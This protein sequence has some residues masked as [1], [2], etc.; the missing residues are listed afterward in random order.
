MSK[1]DVENH[2]NKFSKAYDPKDSSNIWNK[3][4]DAMA[5]KTVVIQALKLCPISIEA[6]DAVIKDERADLKDVTDDVEYTVS[7]APAETTETPAIEEPKEQPKEPKP[8]T[9]KEPIQPSF[10]EMNGMT[11]EE[12]AQADAAFDSVPE[13]PQDIF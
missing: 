12:M 1:K 9:K 6:T 5:L 8:E 10:D 13:N 11:D 3:N 2:R 4:F 7:D